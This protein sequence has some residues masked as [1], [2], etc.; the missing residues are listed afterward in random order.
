[1]VLSGCGRQDGSEITEAVSLLIALNSLGAQ[2]QCFA[3]NME[4]QGR[5]LLEESQRIARGSAKDLT[6]LNSKDFDALIF[7]GGFG[8]AL[9]LCDWASQ[10]AK[11]QVHPEV[12]K[13]IL[14]FHKS[15]KP[16]GAVCIAPVLLAL[17]LGS[18]HVTLT[19]GDD[20][21]TIS[22]VQKTGAHH[23]ICNVDDFISDRDHKIVTSP[24]YMYDKAGPHEVFKGIEGLCREIFEMA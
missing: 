14:D 9:H 15:G 1:M 4:F 24:A 13:Q 19:L 3:P 2:V 6:T 20:H 22:E 7:P 21:E 5:N 17:T 18:K 12:K 11:A 10:G 16:I 8:A 23:E